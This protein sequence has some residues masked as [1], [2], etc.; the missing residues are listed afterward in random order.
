MPAIGRRGTWVPSGGGDG[1]GG[2]GSTTPT[3]GQLRLD[4]RDF[5]AKADN[6]TDN[7]GPFQAALDAARNALANKSIIGAT[8]FIPSAPLPYLMQSPVFV[9]SENITIQG[10]GDGSYIKG[11]FYSSP[12]F[13]FGV[14]R[15]DTLSFGGPP[16]L[17]AVDSSHRPD[18]FG[19]LDASAVATTGSRWGLRTK[20]LN[21][22]QFS[23][24]S[25]SSGQKSKKHGH[26]YLDNWSETDEL[27]VEFCYEPG[28]LT[29]SEFPNMTPL[30]MMGSLYYETSPLV[31]HTSGGNPSYVVVRF[32]TSDM[33]VGMFGANRSFG[34]DLTDC[35]YP[36]HLAIQID[37]KNA[38]VTAFC[39]GK[40]K[41][42]L[43]PTNL[44]NSGPTPFVPGLKLGQNEDYPLLL[45]ADGPT[46]FSGDGYATNQA[47]LCIYGLRFSAAIRYQDNGPTT[48][49]TRA[50]VPATPVNDSWR[51]FGND[52]KTITY[53]AGTDNPATSDRIVTAIEGSTAGTGAASRG[54]LLPCGFRAG[55]NGNAIRDVS[56]EMPAGGAAV[57][58]GP[59]LDFT[60]QRVKT[61]GGFWGI[62]SLGGIAAYYIRIIDCYLYGSDA[63]VF[64]SW[65]IGYISN[66]TCKTTGRVALRFRGCSMDV[67]RVFL[68]FGAPPSES[69]LRSRS[70]GYGGAISVREVM[71]DYEGDRL[72]DA[73][74]LIENQQYATGSASFTLANV[75][76]G[77]IGHQPVVALCD[78]APVGT[79]GFAEAQ[80][81][82]RNVTAAGDYD[83]FL[84]LDGPRWYGDVQSCRITGPRLKHTGRFGTAANVL[85]REVWAMPGPP[86]S[87]A[88][89]AGGHELTVTN[90]ADGQFTVWRCVGS[91]A[92]GTSVPPVWAGANPIRS[93]PSVMAGY[94]TDHC[95]VTGTLT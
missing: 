3:F 4:V 73:A 41:A 62:G 66:V 79:Q 78:V 60:A 94:V 85:I 7:S 35:P 30:L 24:C 89:V 36:R 11:H 2:E 87:L 54:F 13:V 8:I 15:T 18:L 33:P 45:G 76:L 25:M 64:G 71:A 21:F 32:R 1:G 93:G 61:Y 86:K 9:E 72:S 37:L 42:I 68:A 81:T 63:C 12:L 65:W 84:Q 49:Q 91:G 31:I 57:M 10:E 28:S 23:A 47:D 50:D 55:I 16:R 6:A 58:L 70:A 19:K 92:Y 39:N 27:T 20:Q 95:F 52:A 34:L 53:L 40:Q 14:K 88:W 83:V 67:D 38:N 48:N 90:A 29:G 5:G 59:V 75:V 22:V 44:A 46:G 51:Y 56:I 82:L 74:F 80:A 17:Y 69:I 26:P 43:A 77:T